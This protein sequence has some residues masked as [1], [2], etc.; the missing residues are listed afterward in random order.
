MLN[1]PMVRMNQLRRKCLR[2]AWRFAAAHPV[3]S[4][5]SVR[6]GRAAALQL[7]VTMLLLACTS[8]GLAAEGRL[9]PVGY[10]ETEHAGFRSDVGSYGAEVSPQAYEQYGGGQVFE[11][12]ELEPLFDAPTEGAP[13]NGQPGG[14]PPRSFPGARAGIFQGGNLGAT[15][16]P[17]GDLQMV[18][19]IVQGSFGFPF[20][21]REAPVVFTPG[22]GLHLLDG[23][24]FIDVPS[25]LHDAWIEARF[26][27]K[28]SEKLMLDLAVGVGYY[29]DFE[30]GTSDAIRITGRAL[31]LYDWSPQT[32][33]AL[34]VVYLDRNDVSVLPAVGI[35]WSPTPDRRLELIFPRPRFT[36]RTYRFEQI[37]PSGAE[38][39]YYISGEFGGGTWSVL[40]E[41]DSLDELTYQDYRVIF[42]LERKPTG[43]SP[44]R[45][46][47]GYVFGRSL[48]YASVDQDYDVDSTF[49][50]RLV[51]GF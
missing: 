40:R 41:D 14:G 50:A 7:F 13:S 45:L 33:V 34:G 12:D 43:L 21:S 35:T 23:P 19:T 1:L 38:W 51:W 10:P 46:E 47:A 11:G 16:L 18:D 2:A 25:Q 17:S 32:K 29:S 22:Y 30:R 6:C 20:P 37:D 44:S 28:M 24:T 5:H 9:P 26:P 4:S 27:R 31:A 8:A 48:E 42:G 3:H 15:W 39:W 36:W 49:M